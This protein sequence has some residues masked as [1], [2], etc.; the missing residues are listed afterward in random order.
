MYIMSSMIEAVI[1]L[2]ASQL[3]SHHPFTYLRPVDAAFISIKA[4][5]KATST[6][7]SP[8]IIISHAVA[9]AAAH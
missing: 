2:I 9:A 3:R 8:V 1:D 6:L 4:G 5:I 7:P